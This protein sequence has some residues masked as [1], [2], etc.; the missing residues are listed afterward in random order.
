MT[1]GDLREALAK[2][3]DSQ[4]LVI[5]GLSA[6]ADLPV[7]GIEVMPSGDKVI[8]VFQTKARRR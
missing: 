7:T 3:R 1:V 5:Y 8:L 4:K 2:A 6:S